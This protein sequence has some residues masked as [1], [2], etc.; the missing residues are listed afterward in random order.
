MDN[1]RTTLV[2]VSDPSLGVTEMSF[3]Y[4]SDVQHADERE[5]HTSAISSAVMKYIAE[6]EH[7]ELTGYSKKNLVPVP[8]IQEKG[9]TICMSKN[10]LRHMYDEWLQFTKLRDECVG[11]MQGGDIA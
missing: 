11:N 9:N 4:R 7:L 10:T 2:T 3:T 8:S 5:T 1:Q 6:H